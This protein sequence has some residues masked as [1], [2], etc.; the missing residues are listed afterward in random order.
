MYIIDPKLSGNVSRFY[1]HSCMPNMFVQSVYVDTHDKRFPLT[2]FFAARFV[3]AG[4][5]LT[6]NYNYTVGS[7]RGRKLACKCGSIQCL[8]R[9]L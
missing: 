3:E 2:A 7:A 9:L 1:N 5:E 6:W 8:G 4:A